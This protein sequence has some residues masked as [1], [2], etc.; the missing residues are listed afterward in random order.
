MTALAARRPLPLRLIRRLFDLALGGLLCLTPVTSIIALGWIGR[1]IAGDQGWWL[2]PQGRGAVPR[3][4]GGLAANIRSGLR[5][6]MGLSLWTLPVT[7]AWAGAWWAGWDNSFN[8]GYEQAAVGPAVFLAAWVLSLPVLAML[9]FA[10]VH[11]ATE[12]RL[13]A[14]LDL[15]RIAR[16]ARAAGW[17]GTA[18]AVLS[19]TAALPLFAATALPVFV[20]DLVPG[21]ATLPPEAQAQVGTRI[22]LAAALWSFAALW[23][24]RSLA[25]RI[26]ARTTSPGRMTSFWLI[27][28]ALV[29][30]ALPAL[31]TFG[32]FMAFAPHRWVF[33]PL[34]LLPWPG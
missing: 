28:T 19:V 34:I 27:P 4:F 32:Q 10:F 12:R 17:R 11:G 33:H 31:V 26:A 21:F 2:G 5:L 8:K 30:A 25:A 18:L 7:L 20:E 9:P 22:D 29:W 24:L 3:L 23:A 16:M 15:P 6:A 13:A 1:R 14:F